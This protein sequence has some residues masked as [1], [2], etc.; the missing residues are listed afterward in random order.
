M[1]LIKDNLLI[2]TI[3]IGL[4]VTLSLPHVFRY[5]SLGSK[6]TTLIISG[7]SA[8]QTSWEETY[9][10]ATEANRIKNNQP[11]NDPYIYEYR[12]KSSPLISEFVPSLLLG[13]PSKFLSI[14]YMFILIKII[15]IPAVVLIWYL[16]AREIGYS[17]IISVASALM[18]VILQKTFAYLPYINQLYS[19]QFSNYLEIQRTYFPL[20]SSFSI[21]ISILLVIKLLKSDYEPY[22]KILAGIIFGSLFYTYFFVWTIFWMSF[23]ILTV[24]LV[25]K[26][27]FKILKINR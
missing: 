6:Y 1:K 23:V 17:K 27:Q 12:S 14:P 21:S 19:Y 18:G 11:I 20:I 3:T 25:L 22:K 24:T 5:L 10:Y 2:I 4:I 26:K 7:T 15:L 16:I 9:T 13:I 8:T